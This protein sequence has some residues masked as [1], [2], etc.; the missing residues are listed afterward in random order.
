MPTNRTNETVETIKT[1]RDRLLEIVS[2]LGVVSSSAGTKQELMDDTVR[3]VMQLTRADGAV[4]ELVDGDYLEYQAASGSVAPYVGLRLKSSSSMSGLCVAERR[5]IYCQDTTS[6]LRVDAAACRKV[7]AR[8]MLV[9][10]LLRGAN[11]VGVIKS[12]SGLPNA[13]DRIDEYALSLFAQFIGGVV[14]RQAETDRSTQL[15]EHMER[16]ALS[17]DLTQ[18][19]NRAAWQDALEQ[20]IARV[21]RAHAPLAV[22]YLDLNGFK[23]VNDRLGHAAGDEVLKA[24]AARLRNATRQSDFVARLGGDEFAV[25]LEGLGNVERDVPMVV[26]KV[27]DAARVGIR[28]EEELVVC[29]PSVGVA[30]QNG[31]HYDAITLMRHADQA[32]YR[33]KNGQALFTVVACK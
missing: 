18:L 29:L 30:F 11:A 23:A 1:E 8:S 22:M 32:M 27:L 6:D 24:F 33:T 13:F 3:Q 9:V 5:I 20:A 19:P 16:R 25:M 17:D 10:P 4:V 28:W 14:A 15:A 21:R 7:G 26:N 12:V 31:P 2:A